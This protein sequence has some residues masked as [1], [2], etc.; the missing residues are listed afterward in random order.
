MKRRN[1]KLIKKEK[2]DESNEVE[3]TNEHILK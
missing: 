3:I 1:E 2:S